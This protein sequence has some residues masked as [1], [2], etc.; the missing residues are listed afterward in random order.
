M[1]LVG[2]R[3]SESRL[4]NRKDLGN[5]IHAEGVPA[6]VRGLLE[7]RGDREHFD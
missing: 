4:R 5:I 7:S 2:V 3:R 1:C 6:Q